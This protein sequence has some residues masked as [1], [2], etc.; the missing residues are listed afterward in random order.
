M[1]SM[2]IA[3]LVLGAALAASAVGAVSVDTTGL[4]GYKFFTNGEPA[5][6]VVVGSKAAP[7][8]GVVAANIAAMIGNLAYT[9]KTV[10]VVGAD[11]LSCGSANG[12]TGSCTVDDASK[13]VTL[14]VTVPGASPTNV[15]TMKTYINDF[16]DNNTEITRTNV[17]SGNLFDGNYNT[18][19]KALKVTKDKTAV[20]SLANDGKV[21]NPRNRDVKQDQTIFVGANTKYET[22]TSYKQVIADKLRAAYTLAFSEPLPLCWDTSKNFTAA[23]CP[24]NDRL[25]E[26]H[27]YISFLGQKWVVTGF[28]MLGNSVKTLTLGKES[29]Y[30]P[31]MNIDDEIVAPN[32][33]KVKLKSVSA[34]GYGTDSQPLA[35]FEITS[36]SGTVTTETLKPAE[37]KDVA[38]ITVRVNKVFPGVNSVNYADV[39]LYADKLTLTTAT[40]IDSTTHQY[41]YADIQSTTS[42][43][44]QAINNLTLYSTYPYVKS[45]DKWKAGEKLSLIRGAEAFDITYEGLDT[46]SVSYDTLNF[47]IQNGTIPYNASV[48]YSGPFVE[49][50]SGVSNA[51]QY[52]S[53][54]RSVV[55]IAL[56]NMS[57]TASYG[58]TAAPTGSAFIQ[59]NDGFWVAMNGTDT[60]P[61]AVNVTYYYSG[62]ENAIL[63]VGGNANTSTVFV[64]EY[65]EDNRAGV[66]EYVQALYDPNQGSAG[67]FVDADASTVTSKIGYG[68]GAPQLGWS[69][70]STASPAYESGFVTNRGVQFS[71]IGTT[72]M[73]LQYPKT[74]VKAK[75]TLKTTGTNAT[76]GTVTLG[77]LGVGQSGTIDTGY[78]A[79]VS[80]IAATSSGASGAS[81]VTGATSLVASPAT[82][83]VVAQLDT[84]STP[85]VVIDKYASGTEPLI[86]VGGPVV[87][88]MAANAGL[89]SSAGK[90]AMV[91]VD[92]AKIYVAGYTAQDTVD[93]GAELISW[94]AA[95]RATIRG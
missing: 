70:A 49:I 57:V 18:V 24:A 89:P 80:A 63:G 16:L 59:N 7:T 14:S 93:A 12:S 92:G 43:S 82:A 41:W 68:A 10:S 51:F 86:V 30:S 65:D 9:E 58:H 73:T 27:T 1:K 40:Q 69:D 32:G 52:G 77:P 95:N 50:Q 47:N 25:N 34:F 60:A 2:K 29:A 36:A 13:K 55:R 26:S 19:A 15:Y 22:S 5:V 90:E 20:V 61:G 38:G 53:N 33:A 4:S 23:E 87:N 54:S 42:G 44:S 35:S 45:D 66:P 48:S 74:V 3:P 6:K 83:A 81:A 94:L 17:P 28:T 64:Q 84:K 31:Y 71:S 85:L 76:S 37:E 72:S 91:K 62:S 56:L 46:A 39:S 67:Q 8:D 88:S 21:A 11:G 79:T 75:Y 78:V